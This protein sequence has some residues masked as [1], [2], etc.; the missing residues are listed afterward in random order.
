[1]SGLKASGSTAGEALIRAQQKDPANGAK[2]SKKKQQSPF[3]S[4][5][6]TL[7]LR[8]HKH[9][10]SGANAELVSLN[11]P[12]LRR[13]IVGKSASR[14]KADQKC[15]QRFSAQRVTLFKYEHVKV[16]NCNA[17]SQRS[18]SDSSASTVTSQSTVLRRSSSRDNPS[19]GSFKR[20][21]C[22]MSNGVLEIYQIITYNVK[23]PPQ[24][25][26]YL[27]L[28]RKGNI[29]HPILP[30]LQV[31]RLDSPEFK[32]S[33]LLFNPERFWEIEFLPSGELAK[34]NDQIIFEFEGIISTI[35]SY[36]SEKSLALDEALPPQQTPGTPDSNES[37]LEYLLEDSD[38]SFDENVSIT[39]STC[40]KDDLIHDAF[41]KAMKN[42]A[43]L[44]A[45]EKGRGI[46]NK[47]FSSYP[48]SSIPSRLQYRSPIVRSTSFPLRLHSN[49]NDIVNFNILRGSWM[50]I[51]LDD[52]R[53]K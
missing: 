21:T 46:E 7:L 10:K 19:S 22:L 42:I 29:I 31:T 17:S 44:D 25:M 36:K 50:D 20:E 38:E 33:I 32:I 41:Q 26:T 14:E 24:K 48:T 23:S 28:G 12:K 3:K 45:S 13:D 11:P 40:N 47:R 35:C 39:G 16:M 49:N 6:N 1:M 15:Q 8:S 4:I 51:S 53:D 34:L 2:P 18:N 37:D 5:K 9:K 52:L 27:C 43:Y 30:R